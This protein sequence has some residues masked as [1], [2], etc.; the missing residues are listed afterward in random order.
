M[1]STR[2]AT[3]GRIGFVAL[4]GVAIG[5]GISADVDW[6]ATASQRECAQASGLCFGL[7]PVVGVAVGVVAGV[8]ACWLGLA[9][10]RLRP[11]V[12]AVPVAVLLLPLTAVVYLDVVPGGRLHPSWLFGLVTGA[13]FALLAVAAVVFS[14]QHP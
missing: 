10:A 5:W 3:V 9:V 11:L 8:V 1:S 14:K 4:L 6:S 13:V 12:I 7:A 2:L